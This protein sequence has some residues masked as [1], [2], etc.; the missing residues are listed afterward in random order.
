[1]YINGNFREGGDAL[2]NIPIHTRGH[3]W[4]GKGRKDPFLQHQGPPGHRAGV[5]SAAGDGPAGRGSRQRG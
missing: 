5:P 2:M 4:R 3:S 1:M